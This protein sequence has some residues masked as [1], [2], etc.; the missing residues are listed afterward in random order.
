MLARAPRQC[1]RLLCLQVLRPPLP[2]PRQLSAAC[3]M[4]DGRLCELNRLIQAHTADEKENGTHQKATPAAVSSAA[5]RLS[6][7]RPSG[8]LSGVPPVHAQCPLSASRLCLHSKPSGSA[9]SNVSRPDVGQ[10]LCLV[11]QRI[12]S[13]RRRLLAS[14][15]RNNVRREARMHWD[16]LELSA[17]RANRKWPR[18]LIMHAA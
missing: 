14:A 15:D 7:G 3:G 17:A 16:M 4:A 8:L 9:C 11:A 18:C 5:R 1:L 13:L 12:G 2:T 6:C 10:Q